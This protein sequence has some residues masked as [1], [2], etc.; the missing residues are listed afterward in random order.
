MVGLDHTVRIACVPGG[1]SK[2]HSS[3]HSTAHAGGVK[4]SST[5]LFAGDAAAL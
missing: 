3:K 4:V 5:S 2:P 1:L